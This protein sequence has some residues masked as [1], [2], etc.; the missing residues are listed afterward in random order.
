MFLKTLLSLGTAVAEVIHDYC[1][2]HVYLTIYSRKLDPIAK[3]VLG[4]VNALYK[5]SHICIVGH[6]L[7]SVQRLEDGEVRHKSLL[8]LVE[9]MACTIA[10]VEDVEQFARLVEL[11]EALKNIRPLVEET[12]NFVLKYSSTGELGTFVPYTHAQT[13]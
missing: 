8:D 3:A 7:T 4:C 2:S 10:Y 6:H 9:N 5:V 11:K 13:S 1:P 12:T